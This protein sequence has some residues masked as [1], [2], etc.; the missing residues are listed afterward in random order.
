MDQ[1]SDS[2]SHESNTHNCIVEESTSNDIPK[3]VSNEPTNSPQPFDCDQNIEDNIT[4]PEEKLPPATTECVP[5]VSF[6][7]NQNKKS[8]V[9]DI[10]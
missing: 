1:M 3:L 4:Q 7:T 9:N 5:E 2:C 6:P 8:I 10:V